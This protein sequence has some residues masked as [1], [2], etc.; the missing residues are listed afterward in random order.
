MQGKTLRQWRKK[1]GITLQMLSTYTGIAVSV[2]SEYERNK[3]ETS[4]RRIATLSLGIRQIVEAQ[5]R[6]AAKAER[7]E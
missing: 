6:Q 2:I 4:H 7:E 3:R 5:T 1:H